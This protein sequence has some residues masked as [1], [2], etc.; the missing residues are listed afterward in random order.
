VAIMHLPTWKPILSRL[1][2]PPLTKSYKP[3][4]QS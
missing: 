2:K 4:H 3:C 1:F